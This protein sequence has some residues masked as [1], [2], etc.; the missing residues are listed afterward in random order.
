MEGISVAPEEWDES[1]EPNRA[2]GTYIVGS[3]EHSKFSEDLHGQ[4]VPASEGGSTTSARASELDTYQPFSMKI[5]PEGVQVEDIPKTDRKSS[6]RDAEFSTLPEGATVRAN[7]RQSGPTSN[8]VYAVMQSL[9]RKP[10]SLDGI[11]QDVRLEDDTLF[12]VLGALSTAK[13]IARGTKKDSEA[14]VFVLTPLGRKVARRF[15]GG[16]REKKDQGAVESV[17]RPGLPSGKK[18]G[19]YQTVQIGKDTTLQDIHPV[20]KERGSLEEETPFKTLRPEDV[21]PQLK[22][23]KPLPKEVLQPME[24]RVQSDR[25]T[26]IRGTID[27]T[28]TEKR[29]QILMERAKKERKE[30]SRFGVEQ[31]DKPR[32]SGEK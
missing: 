20:G 7:S 31:T 29:T 27:T 14:T 25:G 4:G 21:N 12:A 5:T 24:M 9:A 6:I 16:Q 15:I 2:Y 11:K 3:E 30:K 19:K 17:K 18:K 28:D 1:A 26:D 23:Q 32:D 22:G 8:D 10:R 13:L